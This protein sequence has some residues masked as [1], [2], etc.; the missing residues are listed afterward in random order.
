MPPAPS[1]QGRSTPPATTDAHRI[2]RRRSLAAASSSE[3]KQV[4]LLDYGAGNVRS[5][6]NALKRLGYEVKNV[7]PRSRLIWLTRVPADDRLTGVQA[8]VWLTGVQADGRTT[9]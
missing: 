3:A 5:V 7:R 4:T 2:K 1:L 8:H 9:L 6:R